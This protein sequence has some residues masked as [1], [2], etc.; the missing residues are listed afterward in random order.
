ML[1]RL[2]TIEQERLSSDGVH[3]VYHHDRHHQLQ[4][5]KNS[6]AHVDGDD[7]DVR[8]NYA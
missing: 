8:Q 7:V 3:G 5:A 1:K 4:D 2:L 6:Q